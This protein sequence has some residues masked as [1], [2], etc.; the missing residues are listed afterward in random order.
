MATTRVVEPGGPPDRV[1][2]RSFGP[3]TTHAV[4]HHD[5][6]GVDA[7]PAHLKAAVA[8]QPLAVGRHLHA[9][10][11]PPVAG[12]PVEV[13]P[14]QQPQRR[15]PRHHAAVEPG[16]LLDDALLDGSRVDLGGQVATGRRTSPPRA[17]RLTGRRSEPS[18][19]VDPDGSYD[20]HPGRHGI[21]LA[22]H[23]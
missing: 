14:A 12:Q 21:P 7:D 15:P 8:G 1:E 9:Q 3:R 6:G 18:L 17:P 5:V 23:A 13:A 22:A 19:R 2:D 10:R 11:R 16:T 20:A 4:P